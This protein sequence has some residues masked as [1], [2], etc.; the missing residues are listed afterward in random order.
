MAVNALLL[1]AVSLA[2][3]AGYLFVGAA[4]HG[5]P[6]LT[7]TA[8]MS[9]VAAALMLPGTALLR[10]PLLQPLRRRPW[11]PLVMALTAVA[12]P[13]L[14]VVVAE[15]SIDADLA[16]ILGTTV[17][18]A[19]LLL[20]VFL[21]RETR[22]TAAGLLGVAVALA[23]MVIFVGWRDLLSGDAELVG[24]LVMM[25]GG[26][27]FAFNGVLVGRE[28]ADL[29]GTALAT[30]TMVFSVPVL[31]VLA[32]WFERPTADELSRVVVESLVAEGVLGL[33]FAYLA[34]YALVARAGAWFASL[35]A[36]LVPPLGVALVALVGGERP[37]AEHV[38]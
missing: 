16:A 31:V 7:A 32:W 12:L 15:R 3:A 2:W 4:D 5:L 24:I 11:V 20:T 21:T 19:T 35:Y 26:V 30:W 1:V 23:G 14:A 38:L 13:N 34:Y 29:D 9:F 36:F 33:A 28:T 25:A 17:P 6:P 37:S 22:P 8:A 10:R 18:V 27:V